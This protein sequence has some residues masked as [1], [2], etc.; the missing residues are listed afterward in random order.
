[1][2][3]SWL[4]MVCQWWRPLPNHCRGFDC[5]LCRNIRS[6]SCVK[7]QEWYLEKG[8]SLE[9]EI[10]TII[11]S[12]SLAVELQFGWLLTDYIYRSLLLPVVHHCRCGV[13][14]L[15]LSLSFREIIRFW[16]QTISF[17]FCLSI[18]ILYGA[19][20]VLTTI[21]TRDK[22]S[23]QNTHQLRPTVAHLVPTRL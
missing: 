16:A 4:D 20:K 5:L 23:R 22:D 8:R 7:R 12:P 19:V 9:S 10:S 14:S 15:S 6:L 21:Q 2:D 11:Y 3:C 18:A 1:M 17:R 13:F